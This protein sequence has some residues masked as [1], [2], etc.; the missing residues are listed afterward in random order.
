MTRKSTLNGISAQV[1]IHLTM[2]MNT[3]A[4]GRMDKD[5][6]KGPSYFLLMERVPERGEHMKDLL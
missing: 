5:M 3:R 4:D 6:A 1:A 2:V